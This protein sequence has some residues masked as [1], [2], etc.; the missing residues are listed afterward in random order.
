MT[1]LQVCTICNVN[2]SYTL[3]VNV[4]NEF[5]KASTKGMRF[6]KLIEIILHEVYN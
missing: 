2:I 5:I 6:V 3:E 1:L 4:S